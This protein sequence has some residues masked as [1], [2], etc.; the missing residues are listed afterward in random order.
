MNDSQVMASYTKNQESPLPIF[1]FSG[2]LNEGYALDWSPTSPG[3]LDIAVFVLINIQ[4]HFCV[5][6]NLFVLIWLKWKL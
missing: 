3:K 6:Q 1:S 5:D 4:M 2:H